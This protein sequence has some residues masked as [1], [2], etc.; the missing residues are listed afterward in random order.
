MDYLNE[1]YQLCFY[2]SIFFIVRLVAIMIW[3]FKAFSNARIED[4]EEKAQNIIFTLS[5]Q[6]KYILLI[7]VGIIIAFL[8]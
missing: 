5:T 7:S 2:A 3:K 1:I 4:D 6:D 8:F